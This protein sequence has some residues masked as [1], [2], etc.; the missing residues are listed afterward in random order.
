MRIINLDDEQEA[1]DFIDNYN[2]MV[3]EHTEIDE[4]YYDY[5]TNKLQAIEARKKGWI[6][7]ALGFERNCD[8]VY[9]EIPQEY[10]W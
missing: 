8:I 6:R 10:R 3:I 2:T 4:I 9:K 5:A 1:L 7:M